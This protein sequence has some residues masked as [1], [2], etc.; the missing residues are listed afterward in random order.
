MSITTRQA[1]ALFCN[2]LR[3]SF[4]SKRSSSQMRAIT[5]NA[6][7]KTIMLR[8]TTGA[9]ATWRAAMPV[10]GR[11]SIMAMAGITVDRKQIHRILRL[12]RENSSLSK[13]RRRTASRRSGAKSAN[14]RILNCNAFIL[15]HA[16]RQELSHARGVMSIA[17]A[18]ARVVFTDALRALHRAGGGDLD[19]CR[20]GN[21]SHN[22]PLS[23]G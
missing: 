22:F 2:S 14:S 12:R 4:L 23:A 19:F 1:P 8:P 18:A 13:Q 7:K 11:T 5:I 16:G 6:T 3:T 9:N 21:C 15:G 10:H 17:N 20:Q